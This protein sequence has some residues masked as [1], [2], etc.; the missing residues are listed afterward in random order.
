MLVFVQSVL[1]EN[2]SQ[3]YDK[4]DLAVGVGVYLW[5]F[6]YKKR[7]NIYDLKQLKTGKYHSQVKLVCY[8]H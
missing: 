6:I 8:P 1:Q 7:K 4:T 3:V 5:N 2:Q